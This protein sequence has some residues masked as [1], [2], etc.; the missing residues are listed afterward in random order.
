MSGATYFQH[1][2]P[3]LQIVDMSEELDVKIA[4]HVRSIARQIAAFRFFALVLVGLGVVAAVW[5]IFQFSRSASDL[6]KLGSFLSGGAGALWTL[7][8]LVLIYVAF[9]GQQQQ[10]LQQQEELRLTREELTQTR[11]EMKQQTTTFEAQRFDAS[12]FSLLDAHEEFVRNLSSG[13]MPESV[14]G[15]ELFTVAYSWL[16]KATIAGRLYPP[17]PLADARAEYEECYRRLESVLG[18]YF[19]SY[20]HV[21][22]FVDGRDGR[23]E[24]RIRYAKICRAR[25][26]SDEL[27]IF[28]YNLTTQE[29]AEFVPLVKR[30]ALLKHLPREQLLDYRLHAVNVSRQLQDDPF[31]N[32][33]MCT[34]DD[35]SVLLSIASMNRLG[36]VA[37]AR[38]LGTTCWHR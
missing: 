19:R 14:R 23:A 13:E 36:C 29:G 30:Y 22:S 16:R 7:A 12:F 26:S 2:H 37:I 34:G 6:E 17:F 18:P 1:L 11:Q 4:E 31:V 35:G 27:L 24:D 33:Q 5:G 25:L 20:Y 32:S 8:G 15:R 10:V 38:R 21:V 9:L 28:F 3:L